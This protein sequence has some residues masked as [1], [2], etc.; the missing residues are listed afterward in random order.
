MNLARRLQLR[1]VGEF[2]AQLRAAGAE[3]VL[4]QEDLGCAQ[5]TVV[6]P[7]VKQFGYGK[8]LTVPP[9]AEAWAW[10]RAVTRA[11]DPYLDSLAGSD[12]TRRW[13]RESSRETPGTKL[14][15]TT[16]HYWFHLGESQAV[17][18]LLGHTRLPTFVG[19]FGKSQ[20]RP[21]GLA[22]HTGRSKPYS[23]V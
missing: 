23:R 9:L 8:P 22:T 17:R 10:W 12:L 15:R 19:G 14:H 18:Q 2:G 3:T 13:R 20:Y 7:E 16:Y 5:D 11:A 1:V 6:V 21:E 4:P